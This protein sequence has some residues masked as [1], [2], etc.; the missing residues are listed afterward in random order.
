M[1]SHDRCLAEIAA[2]DNN[3]SIIFLGHGKSDSLFGASFPSTC[4]MVSDDYLAENPHEKHLSEDFI[5]PDNISIFK[6]KKIFCLT[7]NS[8]DS[9][10]EL[11]IEA[12]AKVFLGFGDIPTENHADQD[13]R[14]Y[15]D[16]WKSPMPDRLTKIFKG[17]IQVIIKSSLLVGL[18]EK[19]SYE[20]VRNIIIHKTNLRI[21][22][23]LKHH[24]GIKRR[25]LLCDYLFQFKEEMT[26]FGNS[27][28]LI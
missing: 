26:V 16:Q 3:E 14:L 25:R 22:D 6:E 7:C 23:I 15:L 27:N 28:L 17:D 11:A 21:D 24:K 8:A 5:N 9:L 18:N 19:L 12:G 1:E 10:G 4:G 13:I 20:D 2:H